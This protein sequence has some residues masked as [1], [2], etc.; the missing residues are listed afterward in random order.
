MGIDMPD[1]GLQSTLSALTFRGLKANQDFYDF[2]SLPVISTGR[3]FAYYRKIFFGNRSQRDVLGTLVGKRVVDVGCGLTPYV[4]DSMFQICR[5][6]GIEFFGVDPKFAEGLRLSPL[7]VAKIRIVGGRGR[8]R[9]N[10]PGLENCIGSTADDLPFGDGSIDLILSNFLLYAWI[11]DEDILETIY[12]EFHRVLK[13]GGEVRIYPA[14]ELDGDRI[15]HVGLQDVM[16]EFEIRQR[17]SANWLN[18]GKYPPAYIMTL[19]KK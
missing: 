2:F 15:R 19:K 6:K 4:S 1:R 9:A 5:R 3:S 7:D 12:R 14:P 16:N 8:I 17:F 18:P 11:Q 10:A 13:A